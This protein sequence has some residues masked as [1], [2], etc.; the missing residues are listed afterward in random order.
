MKLRSVRSG[1]TEAVHEATVCAVDRNGRV[2]LHEGDIDEPLF[3]RSS[4]K[5]LQATASVEAGADLEP[6]HIAVACSSHSGFPIHLAIVRAI[7]TRHGLDESALKTPPDWPLSAAARDLQVRHGVT[8]PKRIFHNC[9]GKHAGWLAASA[10]T[11][12]PTESYLDP[13][14]PLQR[15]TIE[16]VHEVSGF[17]PEEVGVDGCGAPVLRGTARSLATVFARVTDDTRFGA[18]ATATHRFASLV[19]DSWRPDGL[20]ARWWSGPVKVG[21]SGW[22]GAGRSGIG[23]AVKSHSGAANVGVAAL[24]E[25]ARRLGMLSAVMEE[26]LHDVM[27]PPVLGGG[28]PVGS[29]V[30][31]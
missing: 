15:R 17:D 2:L 21:A 11:G 10:A 20:F 18:V 25:S 3:Y 13:E 29:L 1:L 28:R 24:A 6:E 5:L 14:H 27:H 23:I 12:W 19:A 31:D 30:A 4:I 16:L 26:R 22:I 7:L 9:S 8:G